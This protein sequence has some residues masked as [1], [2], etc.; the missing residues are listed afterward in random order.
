MFICHCTI[1]LFIVDHNLFFLGVCLLRYDSL[2]EI[3]ILLL[4]SIIISSRKPFSILDGARIIFD[5]VA[6]KENQPLKIFW[7]AS[8]FGF[9]AL[10]PYTTSPSLPSTLLPDKGF[11]APWSFHCL[12]A[13]DLQPAV[14]NPAGRQGAILLTVYYFIVLIRLLFQTC[15]VYH[16][17]PP[18]QP[19]VEGAGY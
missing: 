13:L 7:P 2:K 12:T 11:L 10:V 3:V 9:L 5:D 4:W 15:R 1:L 17:C 14:T 6:I 18:S 19:F 8:F 16:L